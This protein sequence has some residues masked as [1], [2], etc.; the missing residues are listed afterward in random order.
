MVVTSEEQAERA[1]LWL[2]MALATGIA[3]FLLASSGII[4]L[5]AVAANMRGWYVAKAIQSGSG[6]VAAGSALTALGLFGYATNIS[7]F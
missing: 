4:Q 3:A 7:F 6:K 1:Q 2:N 5:L